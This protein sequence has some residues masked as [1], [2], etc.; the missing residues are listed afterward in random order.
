[1]VFPGRKNGGGTG[2]QK[3]SHGGRGD[4]VRSFHINLISLFIV[5]TDYLDSL[6]FDI[7][8]ASFLLTNPYLV[9]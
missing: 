5:K 8:T 2:D 6:Q 4:E 1:M 9:T 3:E 7:C